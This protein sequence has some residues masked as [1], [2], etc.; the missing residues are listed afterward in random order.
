MDDFLHRLEM[1]MSK[2]R[3]T[4][5]QLAIEAEINQ[6]TI[7]A[8]WSKK[9]YPKAVDLVRIAGILDTTAEYLITG[10]NPSLHQSFSPEIITIAEQL[11][12]LSKEELLEFRGFLRTYF[13]MHFRR[14]LDHPLRVAEKPE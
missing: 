9:R 6:S 4:R 11:E 14:N 8:Y 10:T 5:K 2:K 12:T 7:Q 13:M 3:W 1:L